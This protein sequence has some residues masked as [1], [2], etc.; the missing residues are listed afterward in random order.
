MVKKNYSLLFLDHQ[1]T[2]ITTGEMKT[3]NLRK[4][5]ISKF[6][7]NRFH[8]PI[9]LQDGMLQPQQVLKTLHQIVPIQ[10]QYLS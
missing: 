5:G 1:N 6:A 4:I 8:A 7:L 10:G 2:N 9:Q 3:M